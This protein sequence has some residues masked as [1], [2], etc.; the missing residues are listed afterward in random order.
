MSELIDVVVAAKELI[1]DD[2]AR[3]EL[4]RADGGALPAFSPG[5]HIDVH[6]G[7]RLIRQY[8][9]CNEPGEE[10]RYV[11]GVLHEKRGRGG[12][13]AIHEKVKTGDTLKISPPKNNFM[14]REEAAHTLLFAGGIGITP[15]LCMARRLFALGAAFDLHYCCRTESRAAFL[16]ELRSTGLEGHSHLYF[17][18]AGPGLD[19]AGVLDTAPADAHLYVCGPTGFMQAVTQSAAEAQWSTDRIHQEFFVAPADSEAGA[20]SD[21]SAFV[22]ELARSQKEFSIPADKSIVDVLYDAGIEPPVSCEQG[23]CG[24]CVTKI[25]D[26]TPLHKDVYLTDDEKSS[27][28]VMTIC[29]SRALTPRLVLDL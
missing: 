19:I 16:D 2:I 3:L 12:S 15:L 21:S 11:L 24:T 5:A 18:D 20:G 27:N 25:I 29:C 26:G 22:V 6:I 14:L 8:S 28:T 13:S 7:E 10:S 4:R 23:V 17:D 1:A 9:L